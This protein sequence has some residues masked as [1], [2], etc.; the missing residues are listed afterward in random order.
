MGIRNHQAMQIHFLAFTQKA[1]QMLP[2]NAKRYTNRIKIQGSKTSIVHHSTQ[3]VPDRIANHSV[4][5][6]IRIDPIIVIDVFHLSE[7]QLAWRQCALTRERG[8]GKGCPELAGE[9]SRGSA[10]FP[11][12]DTDGRNLAVAHQ[13]QHSHVVVGIVGH[14]GYLDD[15]GVMASQSR[16]NLLEIFRCLA[17]IVHTDNAFGLAIA[18]DRIGNVRLK[19]D[20]LDSIGDR[21]AQQHQT[22]FLAPFPLSLVVGAAAGGDD[23][24]D[25]VTHQAFQVDLATDIVE[26]DFNQ[27]G[28]LLYQMSMFRHYM[29]MAATG[30]TYTNH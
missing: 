7:T 13:P 20:I 26:P 5:L 15:I 29:F 8:V 14:R 17:E 4:N 6:G 24:A 12:T 19:I 28:S 11:H 25:P 30:N 27:I 10:D 3:I 2:R 1:C 22:R 18:R 23:W 16:V 21:R 9:N